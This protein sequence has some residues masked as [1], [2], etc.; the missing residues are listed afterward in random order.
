M[1]VL[2]VNNFDVDHGGAGI[3]MYRLHAALIAAGVDSQALVR[4]HLGG[5]PRVHSAIRTRHPLRRRAVRIARL[6]DD[7]PLRRYPRR[8][9]TPW[10][11]NWLPSGIAGEI[12]ALKPD[13]VHLHWVGE[14]LIPPGALARLGVP[15]VW[16]HHDLGGVTGG[17]H[18][19]GACDRWRAGCGMCPQ[20]GSDRA[21]DLSARNWRRKAAAWAGLPIA[22]IGP[23]RWMCAQIAASPLLTGGGVHH[24][25]NAVDPA[26]WRPLDQDWA[27]AALAL[28]PGRRYL[29]FSAA[30]LS[31]DDNKGADLLIGAL[32][33]LAENGWRDQLALILMGRNPP[34]VPDLPFPAHITG[35][36][37]DRIRPPLYYNAAD[38][39]VSASRSENLPNVLLE[40]LACAVPAVAFGVG[41]IPDIIDHQQNGWLARPFEVE[42]LAAGIAW[43]LDDPARAA[44]LGAAGRAKVLAQFSPVTVAEQ[45]IALYQSLRADV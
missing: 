25:P 7:V 11:N 40:A 33:H 2:H 37:T 34:A 19:P 24:I 6:L 4:R 5:D 36:L 17:C 16:T 18:I 27:R 30:S 23:S 1:R 44:A 13:V 29:L 8:A 39:V 31:Y 42:D 22:S 35:Y 12:A 3:A 9:F 21:D 28:P 38:L 20:L 10:S 15:I 43:T 41:G 32:H 26:Q 45:H 14:G